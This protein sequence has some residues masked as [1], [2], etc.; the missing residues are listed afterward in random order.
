MK[1]KHCY[2]YQSRS[3]KK[4]EMPLDK[5][6]DIIQ[7]SRE[8]GVVQFDITGGEPLLRN[9]ILQIAKLLKENNFEM[10]L[11]TN[12]TLLTSDMID[13]LIGLEINEFRIS[14]DGF[15]D[16]H[17]K[18]RGLNNAYEKTLEAIEYINKTKTNLTINV[19]VN[20]LNKNE[21]VP[22]LNFLTEKKLK[23]KIDTIIPQ[24][25]ATNNNQ[26]ILSDDNYCQSL[27]SLYTKK[28]KYYK[29]NKDKLNIDLRYRDHIKKKK[30][31]M[32]CGV[33]NRILF[34]D[35]NGDV[36]FCPTLPQILGNIY[37]KSLKDIWEG[38]NIL[39]RE[40]LQ[41]KYLEDCVYG[42]ICAGGCRSRAFEFTG[43][44]DAPDTY[45][46]KLL[47]QVF[48]YDSYWHLK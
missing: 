30:L 34:I 35:S 37:K 14:L 38:I 20:S 27:L 4:D 5:I 33:G 25:N 11:F 26:L 12:A 47:K 9:D 17:N 6:K 2:D 23:S 31:K 28:S 10:G 22:F 16:N 41:C 29:Y 19:I 40:E 15:E 36:K 13:K 46:C 42:L 24:G 45:E 43:K 44:L 48:G 7:Q 8:L 32:G 39:Q 3:I 21:I 1:C 18:F